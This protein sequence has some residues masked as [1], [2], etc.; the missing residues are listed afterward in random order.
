MGI[1]YIMDI[2]NKKDKE[3]ESTPVE[4]I[5][6]VVRFRPVLEPYNKCVNYYDDNPTFLSLM[7][8]D[9]KISNRK[10]N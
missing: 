7:N 1:L 10:D 8:T 4:N 5:K 3:D 6:V 2:D 9:G